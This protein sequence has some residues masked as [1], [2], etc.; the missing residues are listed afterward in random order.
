MREHANQLVL[1]YLSR[2]NDIAFRHL[3]AAERLDFMNRLRKRIEEYR[4]KSGGGNEADQ[5]RRV[6]AKFGDPEALVLRERRRLDGSPDPAAT[7]S[8]PAGG[9]PGAGRPAP[10]GPAGRSGWTAEPGIWQP[11]RPPRQTGQRQAPPRLVRTR[12]VDLPSRAVNRP[13]RE[14]RP[15]DGDAGGAI[16]LA[17]LFRSKPVETGAVALLGFGGLLL[18]VPLWIFGAVTA[19]FSRTWTV[20]DKWLGLLVPP[21]AAVALVVLTANDGFDGVRDLA[22]GLRTGDAPLPVR[23]AGPVGAL[24]L[25]WRLLRAIGARTVRVTRARDRG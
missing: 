6:L 15:P 4:A 9:G 19:L 12:E 16:E 2:A 25:G 10:A 22:E 7:T 17:A 23:L 1:E 11:T 5:V 14:V 20:L 8:G 21:L 24:Y 18:P 13:A 3:G